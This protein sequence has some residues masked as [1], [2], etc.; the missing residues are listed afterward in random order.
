MKIYWLQSEVSPVD[1]DSIVYSLDKALADSSISFH[2]LGEEGY[3]LLKWDENN[4]WL[5]FAVLQF[6]SSAV[7]ED[8]LL[9]PIFWGEGPTDNLREC[10]HTYWGENG[11]VFY[12]DGKTISLAFKVLSQYFDDMA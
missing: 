10:R 2:K 3:L 7:G 5:K 1:N 9:S 12:P 6:H 4:F 8:V 11:Y